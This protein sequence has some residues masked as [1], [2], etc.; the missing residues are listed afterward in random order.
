MVKYLPAII[1][2]ALC[3]AF[4]AFIVGLVLIDMG[5]I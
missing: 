2:G 1:F 4:E 5:I 3:V